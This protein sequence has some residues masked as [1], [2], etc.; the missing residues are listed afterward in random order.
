MKNKVLDVDFI[1]GQGALTKEEEQAISKFIR[2]EKERIKLKK[3]RLQTAKPSVTR[4]K[5]NGS[6]KKA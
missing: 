2:A 1:G 5:T 6:T 4:K 3:G